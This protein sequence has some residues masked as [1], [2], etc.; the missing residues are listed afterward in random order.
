M[1]PPLRRKNIRSA[2]TDPSKSIN[3]L[4]W[5]AR[6][7]ILGKRGSRLK[8]IGSAARAEI[9]K[10][11]GCRVHLYLHVK[12]DPKWDEDRGLYR[13]IGLDWVE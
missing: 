12:V 13:D 1:P 7:I 4:R 6:A 3:K 5:S 10:F 8:E 2:K 9:S 11:L